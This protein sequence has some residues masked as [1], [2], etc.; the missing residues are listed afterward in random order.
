MILFYLLLLH[1]N[2]A[3]AAHFNGG[4]IT[5]IPVDSYQNGSSITISIQQTYWWIYPDIKCAKNVPS[6]TTGRSTEVWKLICTTDCSTDGGYSLSPINSSTDCIQVSSGL[7]LMTSQRTVN[8]TLANDTHF[9]LTF[10]GNAWV[11]LN[12]PAKYNS[13][14][15]ITTLIDLRMRPDGFINTPPTASVISPRYVIVNKVT[16]IPISVS[17]ADAGDVVRCRW[18]TYT[19]GYRR[20]RDVS[21]KIGEKLQSLDQ[22]SL[23]SE[24][25]SLSI[26]TKRALSCFGC[27]LSCFYSCPCSC[28]SC[29]GTTCTGARCLKL[30]YCVSQPTTIDTTATMK[31]TTS[32]PTRQAIDECGDACYPSSL[33]SGT[34]LSNCTITTKGL[35]TDT[36]YAVAVQVRIQNNICSITY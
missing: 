22:T 36:W 19:S 20:K 23:M 25:K 34:N 12:S 13:Q 18:S 24:E 9:Y 3:Y 29:T 31:S 14:W 7:G 32:Y 6:S 11:A 15:S 30:L 28:T 35:V 26:R 2:I 16:Q 10:R 8:R 27:S 21:E 33:P 1:F 17:D 5:W 4:T